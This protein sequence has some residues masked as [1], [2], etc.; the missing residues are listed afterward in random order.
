MRILLA[1]DSLVNQKDAVTLLER[2]GHIVV[3][4]ND[5]REAIEAFDS[6][7]FDLILMDVQMPEMDGFEA[8]AA[9]R[10]EERQTGKHIPIIAMTAYALKGDR[11]RCLEAGMD[12]YVPKPIHGEELFDAIVAVIGTSADTENPPKDT[13]PEEERFDWNNALEAVWGDSEMRELVL[14]TA[15]REAP[16]LL[17]AVRTAVDDGDAPA[18]LHSAHTLK[19]LMRYFGENPAVNHA[20]ELEM[21]GRNQDTGGAG[22]TLAALEAEMKQFTSTLLEHRRT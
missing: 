13:L 4:A 19:G 9:I 3:V 8:T 14:E 18:L 6:Q 10:I 5:G 16:L 20:F 7:E 21:M 2:E 12:G 22:Q 1:E 11:E 17:A 15:A